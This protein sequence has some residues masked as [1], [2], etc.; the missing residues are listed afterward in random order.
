MT[1]SGRVRID[2]TLDTT[3]ATHA[4]ARRMLLAAGSPLAR[5]RRSRHA[6]PA[7]NTERPSGSEAHISGAHDATAATHAA[8]R[9]MLSAAGS[10]LARTRRSRHAAPAANTERPSGS[11]A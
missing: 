4:A 9:R 10:P 7:A 11:E 2:V 5:T 6:A 3:A 8:A 1:M